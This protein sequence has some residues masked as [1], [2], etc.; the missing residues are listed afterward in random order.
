[1]LKTEPC[2]ICGTLV[3]YGFSLCGKCDSNVAFWDDE[4]GFYI[5]KDGQILNTT[6]FLH[7]HEGALD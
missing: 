4:T 3:E 5:M 1:M 2:E 7:L 6:K